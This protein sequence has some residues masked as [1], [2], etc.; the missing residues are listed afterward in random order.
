[1]ADGDGRRGRARREAGVL[2]ELAQALHAVRVCATTSLA[3]VLSLSGSDAA[4]VEPLDH[5]AGVACR[6]TR[7]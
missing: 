5:A 6:R 2:G 3:A 1:M 4:E 7:R